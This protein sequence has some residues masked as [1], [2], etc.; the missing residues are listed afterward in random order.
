MKNLPTDLK[1]QLVHVHKRKY[2]A[3]VYDEIKK[4]I[5]MGLAQISSEVFKELDQCFV[6]INTKATLLDTTSSERHYMLIEDKEYPRIDYDFESL[7]HIED[8]WYKL[9]RIALESSLG[10]RDGMEGM[11]V[12]IGKFKF[13]F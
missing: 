7:Y 8:Y 5:F 11:E 2:V 13:V 6:Y 3:S 4:L 12:T 10:A 9:H 1:R